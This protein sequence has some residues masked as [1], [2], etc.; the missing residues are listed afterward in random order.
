MTNDRI[1][2]TVAPRDERQPVPHRE[3]DQG[4]GAAMAMA[5]RHVM[6]VLPDD[7]LGLLAR[8]N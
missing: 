1:S 8:L 3:P 6:P 7:M 5:F 2:R 4:Y